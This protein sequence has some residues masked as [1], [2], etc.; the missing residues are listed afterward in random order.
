MKYARVVFYAECLLNLGSA[1]TAF[2][3]P[4]LFVQQYTTIPVAKEHLN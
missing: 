2:F 3:A 4:A 1:V